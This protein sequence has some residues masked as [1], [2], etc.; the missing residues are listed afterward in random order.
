MVKLNTEFMWAEELLSLFF[1]ETKKEGGPRLWRGGWYKAFGNCKLYPPPKAD[2]FGPPPYFASQNREDR[3]SQYFYEEK[4]GRGNPPP[5]ADAF[6][7]PPYF[8]KDETGM[9][10]LAL[11]SQVLEVQ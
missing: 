11:L 2:A 1:R 8:I 4:R 6:G 3:V 9:I 7:P 5:K 10:K